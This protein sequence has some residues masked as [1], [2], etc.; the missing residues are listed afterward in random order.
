MIS[1]LGQR[2]GPSQVPKIWVKKLPGRVGSV[3]FSFSVSD[4]GKLKLGQITIIMYIKSRTCVCL[5][6][7][8]Q[9][10]VL[11]VFN[12]TRTPTSL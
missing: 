5:M 12:L 11:S 8:M 4:S 9:L 1:H 7:A 6:G 2:L 10:N 3:V